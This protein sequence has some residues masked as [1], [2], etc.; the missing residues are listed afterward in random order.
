MLIY[1]GSDCKLL[2]SV[3]ES[4]YSELLLLETSYIIIVGQGLTCHQ[5]KEM[6]TLMYTV[7]K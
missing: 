3:V 2:E 7:R 4:Q 6:F 5:S 1:S